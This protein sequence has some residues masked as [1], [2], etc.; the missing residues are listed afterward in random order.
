[1][2]V[3]TRGEG[4]PDITV[5]GSLHGDEPAGE[6]AIRKILD[7][8]LE[9]QKP[10]KFIIANEEALAKNERYLEADLNR[11][12]P[13]NPDSNLHEERL[14]SEILE[15]VGDT[16][17]LDIH[18]TRSYPDPFAVIKSREDEIIDLVS[19]SNVDYAVHFP[20][21]SGN[22]QEFV[23]GLTV[24][25]GLQGTE[26]ATENAVE[27]I[28]N[29]LAAQGALD[30]DFS[31]SDPDLFEYFETVEG[32]WTFE[33]ENFQKVEE[34]EVYA[35][36]EDEELVAEQDFYPVLMSTHGYEGQLG[37]KAHRIEK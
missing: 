36:R 33:A 16:E 22:I 20:S 35:T 13:G 15:E 28:K 3:V 34:G 5:I 21:R 17:V 6:K 4:L 23:T 11:S 10:V 31:T 18:T 8:N 7:S 26:E 29:F 12:F 9:F 30:L 2:K 14:A 1:M 27:A 32:N 19:E 25:T 37:Y 24:E